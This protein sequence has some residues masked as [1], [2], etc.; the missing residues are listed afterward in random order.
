MNQAVI[1]GIMSGTSLDGVD[2]AICRLARNPDQYEIIRAETIAYSADWITKLKQAE[3]CSGLELMQLHREYGKYLGHLAKQFIG[4]TKVDAIASHGHTIFHNPAKGLTF[5]IGCGAELAATSGITT[6]ADFRITDVAHGGQGAP[7]V[8]A[9]DAT[10]FSEYNYCLNLGGFINI[11][12]DE[13]AKRI[14]FDIAPMNY[15]LNRLAMREGKPF[16]ENGKMA[17]AGTC[18]Q[19][20]L[21]KLN[22]LSYYS[23]RAP[24]SL[25]REWVEKEIFPL[26]NEN[27]NTS[28][29][30]HTFTLHAAEQTAKY[31]QQDGRVLITGGGAYNT[32]FIEELKKRSVAEIVIPE[33]ELINFKE[34]LIFAWLGFL[35]LRN[36]NNALSSVTG[37]RR[38]SCGGAIFCA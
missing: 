34:A 20:L 5:Q 38:D 3:R 18:I 11:S 17:A 8:P 27:Y 15:V 35:R 19:S 25:G 23:A 9:G 16:D 2:L 13:F 1:L 6:V 14:A 36:E 28:D 7:L 21:D 22:S 24:K 12:F 33:S 30:L 31:L 26:L 4:E 29:L 37:A 10:L 32:F